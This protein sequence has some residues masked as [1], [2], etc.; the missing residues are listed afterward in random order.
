MRTALYSYREAESN[1]EKLTVHR[2]PVNNHNKIKLITTQVGAVLAQEN[3]LPPAEDCASSKRGA[4]TSRGSPFRSKDKRSFSAF[5]RCLSTREHLYDW[6]ASQIESKTV[7]SATDDDLATMK[8]ICSMRRWSR[9]WLRIQWL[10]PM[11][12]SIVGLI[13]SLVPHCHSSSVWTGSTSL[14]SFRMSGEQWKAFK[15][16]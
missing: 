7:P 15:D 2:R 4:R 11:G 13:S 5:S 8:R 6:P 12:P 1:L 10:P 3:L 16:T 9:E 14:R